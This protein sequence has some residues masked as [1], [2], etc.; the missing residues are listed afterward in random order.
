MDDCVD[1]WEISENLANFASILDKV[2]AFLLEAIWLVILSLLFTIRN[3]VFNILGICRSNHVSV[4]VTESHKIRHRPSDLYKHMSG[5]ILSRYID[6]VGNAIRR[7]M[8]SLF[9]LRAEE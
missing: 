1:F 3:V 7:A 9:D 4:G 6:E 5:R 8:S 2:V